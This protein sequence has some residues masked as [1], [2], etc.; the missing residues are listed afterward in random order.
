MDATEQDILRLR[1]QA[2]ARADL[3]W[4]EVC[5]KALDGDSPSRLACLRAIAVGNH[6]PLPSGSNLIRRE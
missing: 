5:N 4:V 3:Y 6:E 2:L 1:A